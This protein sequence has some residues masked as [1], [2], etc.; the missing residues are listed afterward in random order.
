MSL[1]QG[2]LSINSSNIEFNNNTI[3]NINFSFSPYI[4]FRNCSVQIFILK[5]KNINHR[6][7][8]PSDENTKNKLTFLLIDSS[9]AVE[10]DEISIYNIKCPHCNSGIISFFNTKYELIIKNS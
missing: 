8:I 9:H 5:A 7:S 1:N 6:I 4:Y 10:I 3:Q 2:L